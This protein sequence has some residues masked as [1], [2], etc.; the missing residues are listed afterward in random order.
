MPAGDVPEKHNLNGRLFSAKSY[1]YLYKNTDVNCS[2]RTKNILLFAEPSRV[3]D[4]HFLRGIARY[5][6]EQAHWNFYGDILIH[7]KEIPPIVKKL[8]FAGI[9]TCHSSP[10]HMEFLDRLNL[11]T[12]IYRAQ[13]PSPVDNRVLVLTDHQ[14][15]GKT[16][17]Q[18]YKRLGYKHFA[19]LGSP[20]S[21]WSKDRLAGFQ[22]ELQ[23][24]PVFIFKHPD[25]TREY[26]WNKGA[27]L[28]RKWNGYTG[29][30]WMLST[31]RFHSCA[32][33]IMKLVF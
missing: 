33:T 10:E 29:P 18:Y 24:N 21:Y 11:P 7:R 8:P 30:G 4:R 6:S 2:M 13:N 12:I 20:S 19:Y 32:R 15:I 17:A 16:A 25:T 27:E 31:S 23:D 22:E 14:K 28:T 1:M 9:I 26:D 3:Y 5:A